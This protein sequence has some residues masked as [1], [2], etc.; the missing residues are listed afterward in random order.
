M[1][2]LRFK[3]NHYEMGVKRGNIFNKCNI[4]FPLHLDSY[5]LEHG[6]KSEL[7]LSSFFPEVCEEIKGITD[8]IKVDYSTFSAWMLCM[9]CCMYNLE[10]NIPLEIRGCTA[11]AFKKDNQVFY[12]RNNDLPPFLEKG[13][14]SEIYHPTNSNLFNITTSSFINGEEGVNEH[15]L[16]VAMTFVLTELSEIRPGFNSCFVVRYLLEKA[17]DV[18]S[19]MSLLNELPIASN[20]NILLAD[21]NGQMLVV[22]CTPTLKNIRKPINNII[23][24]VNSF[25]SEK[26][27]R[28]D[29]AKG[30]DYKSHERYQ[31]VLN[32]L[33]N[34]DSDVIEGIK[35]L[36]SG[37]TGFMCQYEDPNFKTVWST[38]IDLNTLSIQRAEGDPRKTKFIIDDR[39]QK[40]V[41]KKPQR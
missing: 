1:Y 8:T 30:D 22:E 3:G 29:F 26:M 31:N 38:I 40:K 13:S 15:G 20:C 21:K 35:A 37:K 34:L 9:G 2:H 6:R 36:L 19:A 27:K 24:T 33:K 14:K 32:T 18:D 16:V 11:F 28:F 23:C 17:K 10:Q 5:Q 39:L 41:Q 25:T 12:G 4:S 7:I